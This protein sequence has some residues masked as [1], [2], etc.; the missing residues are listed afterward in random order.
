MGFADPVL[1][2]DL[3]Q[4]HTAGADVKHISIRE[5]R[6]AP[7]ARPVF[8]RVFGLGLDLKMIKAN[9]QRLFAEMVEMMASRNR[10][11]R[12]TPSHQVSEGGRKPFF[13]T[14]PSVTSTLS[15][16]PNAA[17]GSVAAIFFNPGLGSAG[18]MSQLPIT[19]D[20][21]DVP[22]SSIRLSRDG[23]SFTASTTAVTKFNAVHKGISSMVGATRNRANV[24]SIEG[25]S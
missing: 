1:G 12:N 11:I 24:P 20:A 16:L 13:G 10:P 21:P 6:Y 3:G 8:L 15:S 7:R 4:R 17:H 23:R 14:R 5:T 18:L 25:G 22:V 9:A 19:G 2:H